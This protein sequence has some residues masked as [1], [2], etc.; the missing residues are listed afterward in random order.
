[1]K[2]F[3]LPRVKK[4]LFSVILLSVLLNLFFLYRYA[5]P[6]LLKLIP[7]QYDTVFFGDAIIEG[8]DWA[9]WLNSKIKKS[10]HPYM[11]TSTFVG[12]LNDQV[13]AYHP[14]TCYLEGGVND[15]LAGIT[16]ERTCSNYRSMIDTLLKHNITPVIQSTLYVNLPKDSLIN[17]HI[18]SLNLYLAS[19]SKERNL[20]FID[21][22]SKLSTN[23]R[24]RSEYT[25]DG[26]HLT[27]EGYDRWVAL[28]K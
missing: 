13:I 20:R 15:A 2:L 6:K 17:R 5:L 26:M 25:N 8:G 3:L 28:I 22:N 4:I 21:V 10:G 27:K 9:S 18:D 7:Q 23:K 16:L 12:S 14:K 11:T 1:M 24:L 19:I